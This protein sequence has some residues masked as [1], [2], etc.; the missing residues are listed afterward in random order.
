MDTLLLTTF[1]LLQVLEGHAMMC[2]LQS[3][4]EGAIRL[5]GAP[6]DPQS[7]VERRM[8]T[9]PELPRVLVAKEDVR[10]VLRGETLTTLSG[11]V[12]ARMYTAEELLAENARVCREAGMEPNLS[13]EKAEEL[14]ATLG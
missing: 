8:R 6:E 4:G 5:A 7:L 10:R 12:Q 13:R 11:T 14:T 1:D 9:N 2:G 3:G